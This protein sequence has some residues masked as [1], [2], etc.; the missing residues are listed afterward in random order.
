MTNLSR[1]LTISGLLA[2]L[3]ALAVYAPIP[4]AGPE[5]DLKVSVRAAVA[6]DSNIFGAATGEVDSA[7]WTLAPRIDYA[8]SLTDQTF[9]AAAYGLTLDRFD[10]RPGD[11]LVDSHDL[12]LRLAHAFSKVT[13]LDLNESFLVSRNPEALLAGVPL[14]TDQSFTRNQ[15]DGRLVTP[16]TPRT[17]VTAKARSTYYHYRN[18]ALGRNLDRTETL[19]GLAVGHALVPEL[20]LVAEYRY[21]DVSYRRGGDLKDKA[22]N[23]LMAG[24]DYDVARKTSLGVRLGGERRTREGERN[25]TAPYAEFSAKHDYAPKSYLV[26]GY[27]YTLEETSD[28]VRFTDAKVHRIFGSV[29]HAVSA[30]VVASGSVAYEPSRLQ[31]RRALAGIDETTVRAGAALTWLPTK[32][33][34]ASVTY[35]HDRVRSD[36]PSRRLRRA[37]VALGAT[38]AF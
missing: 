13:T 34:S 10:R 2:A 36:D 18:D 14:N 15:L 8:A 3:P 32:N 28:I 37:R 9:L 23:Y 24:V 12:N 20:K 29:Q 21:Q 19:F 22:S 17:G 26:G 1:A 6:H 30:L 33:W 11:R 5:K 4:D 38:Y 35:D 27:A 25:V 31:G 16:V 7:I